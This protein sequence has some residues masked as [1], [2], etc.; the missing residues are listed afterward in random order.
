LLSNDNSQAQLDETL[1]E[2][3]E[4]DVINSNEIPNILLDYCWAP[5]PIVISIPIEY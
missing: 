4:M 2:I 3:F 5:E 1:K